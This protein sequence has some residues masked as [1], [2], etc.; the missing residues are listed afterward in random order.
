[1]QVLKKHVFLHPRAKKELFKFP[2]P[3]QVK[4]KALFEKLEIEGKLEEPFAKKLTGQGDFFEL[5]VKH[6]GQ[7]RVIYAYGIEDMVIILSA[8][9]KK[10]KKTPLSKLD[11]AQNRYLLLK[12][13]QK[14]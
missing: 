4:F 5:R 3:A 8:F 6:H 2:R 1:M 14:L 9:M 13:E 10:T 12:K 11:T 7:W